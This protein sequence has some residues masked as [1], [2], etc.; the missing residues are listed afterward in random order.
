MLND[1]GLE[2][3]QNSIKTQ[4]GL[5][6]ALRD[7]GLIDGFGTQAHCFNLDGMTATTL[8]SS[9]DLMQTGGI[10]I[11]VTELDLNGKNNLLTADMVADPTKFQAEQLASYQAIFPTFWSHPAVAGIS[12]WGYVEGSTWKVGTGILQSNGTERPAMTW[13]KSYISGLSNIGYPLCPQTICT[14]VAPTVTATKTYCQNTTAT[15][16]TATG[17]ALKW[18]TVSTGG[19]A[20]ALSP[21]PSTTATGTTIYYVSQTL[22]S[23]EGTRSSIAVTVN[24]LP[25]VNAGSN[26]AICLGKS[27][28]LTATGGTSYAW[29]NGII[30]AS[31]TVSPMITTTYNLTATNSNSCSATDAVV[32][33]VNAL[34]SANT[35]SNVAI[36][37]GKSTTLTATG[38]T[39]YT[40][41]NGINVA[42]NTVSPTIT[43]TYS[44]TATNSNSC[45]ATDAVVV[46]VNALPTANAGSNVAIC[47]GKSTTLTATGGTSY[48]WSNG[49]NVASNTVSPTITTTYNLTATNSNS[50]SATDAVVVTVNA[51][52]TITPYI[53]INTTGWNIN[54]TLTINQGSTVTFGPWPT[55]ANGWSWTG[56]NGFTSNLRAPVLSN[57]AP[58]NQ[59]VYTA[60][61][62]D[63]N[64]CSATANYTI[65]VLTQQSIPLVAGW[66]LISTNV[67]PVDSS[68]ATIFSGL[69]VQEIKTMNSFWRKGQNIAF[70]CLKTISTGQGYFVNMNVADTLIIYGTPSV[71][72][73]NF[74]SLQSGWQLIGCPYQTST[75]FSTIFNTTNSKIIKDFNGYWIP[76]GT[77]NS[78]TS[79]IPGK[80]YFIKK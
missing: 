8:K 17:T 15:A 14:T 54:S 47:L 22:N 79:F 63:A 41:S 29:S 13:L 72:T 7:R 75:A 43:T 23:C 73:Q 12:L 38:G 26:V 1:Y 6:K 30:M 78:I 52:P 59:G 20:L 21:I 70:N 61:Y 39:S 11:Y 40:W 46:T 50:C 16:L 42:S 4:L 33:T 66:N 19:T 68:I 60:I 31:N 58:I 32:V 71:E 67:N 62:T 36:C 56:P 77:T 24:A 27:T 10:P 9:L 80:G 44:L 69:D 2:N 55:V 28:T 3:D 37:L 18:Y 65:S 5:I 35:G 34:P 48:A 45:S 57:I 25:T 51:L 76:T 49:I 53:Q 74:A 64:T